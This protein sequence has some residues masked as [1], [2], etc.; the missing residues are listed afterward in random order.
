MIGKAKSSY[1]RRII[2]ENSDDRKNF[3]KAVSPEK[4]L[5]TNALHLN[6]QLLFSLSEKQPRIPLLLQTV[7][8]HI[9]QMLWKSCFL[10]F[11]LL[12]GTN[13]AQRHVWIIQVNLCSLWNQY[14]LRLFIVNLGYLEE[15][16]RTWRNYSPSTK[17]CS[18]KHLSSANSHNKSLDFFFRFAGGMEICNGGSTL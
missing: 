12:T 9:L 18:S 1:N 14:Q 16:Y 8:A 4:S 3:W 5:L 2:E 15:R 10:V 17:E 7:S 13:W 11:H 6:H